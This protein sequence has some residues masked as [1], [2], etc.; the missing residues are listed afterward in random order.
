LGL[1]KPPA[2]MVA[3]S[4]GDYTF[5]PLISYTHNGDD[6]PQ[7]TSIHIEKFF[8]LHQIKSL[9]KGKRRSQ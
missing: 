4:D 2:I 7:R 5:L 1:P 6:T 8:K 3:V 9:K